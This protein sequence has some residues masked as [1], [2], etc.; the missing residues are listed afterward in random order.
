MS[1]TKYTK[2]YTAVFGKRLCRAMLCSCQVH[3]KVHGTHAVITNTTTSS[4]G[5]DPEPKR[6]RLAGKFHP[7]HLYID[8]AGSCNASSSQRPSTVPVNTSSKSDMMSQVREVIQMAEKCTPRVGKLILQDGPVFDQIQSMFPDKEVKA[9]DVCRGINRMRTCSVGGRGFAPFRRMLGK[10]RS[11]LEVF[12][13]EGWEEWEKLSH[14]Q[15]I[16][17]S[18]P[19]KLMM[20]VF[21]SNKRSAQ[22]STE[23]PDAKEPRGASETT[24][25]RKLPVNRNNR[26]LNSQPQVPQNRPP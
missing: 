20:T 24:G 18:I 2:L 23:M 5:E 14:R 22:E 7:E 11:D 16:R 6:R 21:A 4:A 25:P 13:D 26:S 19:A 12:M 9:I 3:E 10:R 17:A 1:V 8:P 15:Q